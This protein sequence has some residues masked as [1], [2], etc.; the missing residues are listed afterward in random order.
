MMIEHTHPH[1]GKI[2]PD[3]TTPADVPFTGERFMPGYG[4]LEMHLEH[5]HRYYTAAP[6]AAG[7]VLDLGCGVGYGSRLLSSRADHVVGIDLAPDAVRYAR[8]RFPAPN[9]DHLTA[10]CR[11]L[12]FPADSFDVVVCFEL[13]EHVQEVGSVLA[14]ARRV[15]RRRGAL[16]ISTPNRPIYSDA[17]DYRNPH[18]LQEY[19]AEEFLSLLGSHFSHVT[20]Y[21]QR[22][23]AGSWTWS[24]PHPYGARRLTWIPVDPTLAP[25]IGEDRQPMYFVA[26]CSSV[27]IGRRRFPCADSLVTGNVESLVGD[28]D[29]AI[30]GLTERATTLEAAASSVSRSTRRT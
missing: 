7:R 6:M 20:L 9:V 29:R 17:R 8:E 21:G 19:D 1:P 5:L 30:G 13:I 2:L 10:D 15:L 14:E 22:V 24:I 16:V 26:I 23:I 4:G 11:G 28:R 12:P 25:G 18:H 27:R 3:G